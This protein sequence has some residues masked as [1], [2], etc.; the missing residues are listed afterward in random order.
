MDENILHLNVEGQPA[1][2]PGKG[3]NFQARNATVKK[4]A[5]IHGSAN[6]TVEFEDSFLDSVVVNY[7]EA[8]VIFTGKTISRE[9][10]VND[11]ASRIL[12]KS[13]VPLADVL[14]ASEVP[15]SLMI[16]TTAEQ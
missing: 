6:N 1:I 9:L 3:R 8:R 12:L 13:N 11:S 5:V 7:A 2:V 15:V 14:L 16:G 10:R 4:A